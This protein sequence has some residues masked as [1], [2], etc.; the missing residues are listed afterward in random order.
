MNE[1]VHLLPLETG[2]AAGL[3][4]IN[5]GA[6]AGISRLC[7]R[8]PVGRKGASPFGIRGYFFR[9]KRRKPAGVAW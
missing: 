2:F 8:N 9:G 3:L 6:Q 5:I 7:Q 1:F 4:E